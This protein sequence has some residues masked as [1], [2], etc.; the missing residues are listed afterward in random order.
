[1][2]IF[3]GL[4]VLVFLFALKVH[5]QDSKGVNQQEYKVLRLINLLPE[6]VENN[7]V[8]MKKTNGKRALK[9]YIENSPGRDHNYYTISVSEFNG[10]K[11]VP[12]FWFSVNAST[13]AINYWDV[14]NNKLLPYKLWHQYPYGAYSK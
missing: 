1:M 10:M 2:K 7:K 12:H 14:I 4:F 9:A 5:A 8:I 11:L 3:K 6:V 13:Y